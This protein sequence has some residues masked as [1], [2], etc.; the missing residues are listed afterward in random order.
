MD[1]VAHLPAT[2]SCPDALHDLGDAPNHVHEVDAAIDRRP[3]DGG[4]LRHAVL[5]K[6]LDAEPHLADSK[7][8]PP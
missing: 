5:L 1:L 6:I 4:D 2:G 7:A 8:S 3:N